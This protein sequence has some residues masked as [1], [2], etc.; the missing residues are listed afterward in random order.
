MVKYHKNFFSNKTN[1]V[2]RFLRFTTSSG[3]TTVLDLIVFFILTEFFKIYYLLSAAISYIISSTANYFINRK[4][5][6]KD[7]K[8]RIGR[9][10]LIFF[11]ISLFG[12]GLTVFLLWMFVSVF[13][14]YYLFARL[15]V[16]IIEG[17]ISFFLHAF[18]SFKVFNKISIM[19]FFYPPEN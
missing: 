1:I 6:F 18:F 13:H 9:G 15:L 19:G 14:I 5:G 11:V 12:L 7:T 8:T 16:Y 2:F 10:Y 17:T 4:W 3:S